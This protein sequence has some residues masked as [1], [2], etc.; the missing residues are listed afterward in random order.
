MKS[1]NVK[2]PIEWKNVCIREL[3]VNGEKLSLIVDINVPDGG[4]YLIGVTPDGKEVS[5]VKIPTK[6]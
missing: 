1:S 2:H 4:L 3:I 6:G 5:R